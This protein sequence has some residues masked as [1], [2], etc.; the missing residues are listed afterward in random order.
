[1][2]KCSLLLPLVNL[3]SPL[4]KE[5]ELQWIFLITVANLNILVDINEC[6][7]GG[8]C[9]QKCDNE[10]GSF[11]CSC[12]DGFT[13]AENGTCRALGECKGRQCSVCSIR[14]LCTQMKRLY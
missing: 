13:L 7:A 10:V 8:Y 9:S 4:I 1:M 2:Y 3:T 5:L 6:E 14:K 11:Q 12:L